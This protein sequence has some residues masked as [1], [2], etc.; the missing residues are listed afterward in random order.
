MLNIQN[1]EENKKRSSRGDFKQFK[2]D[3]KTFLYDEIDS[4]FVQGKIQRFMIYKLLSE[5]DDRIILHI[6]IKGCKIS[7][8]SDYNK[9]HLAINH[10][11]IVSKNITNVIKD[12][13]NI[14]YNRYKKQY[15]INEKHKTI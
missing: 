4:N 3:I 10:Y 2:S 1:M 6:I 11:D 7:I 9:N 13:Y 8:H 14:C 12:Y 5:Y 15:K